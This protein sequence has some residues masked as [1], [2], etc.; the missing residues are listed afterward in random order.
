[1]NTRTLDYLYCEEK[2]RNDSEGWWEVDLV[3]VKEVF[4][5]VQLLFLLPSS[6]EREKERFV[7]FYFYPTST[8]L[9]SVFSY[10]GLFFCVVFPFS[11]PLVA[12][13]PIPVC[14]FLFPFLSKFLCH[15][16][17]CQ[18]PFRVLC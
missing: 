3:E 12:L 17:Y 6:V 5:S 11:A 18:V 16:R 8:S 15:L 1:M 9:Y 10:W 7:L 4:S 13:H 2:G 14:I